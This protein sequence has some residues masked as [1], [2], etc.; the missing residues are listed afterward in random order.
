MN[1]VVYLKSVIYARVMHITDT[2]SL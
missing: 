1:S 2:L